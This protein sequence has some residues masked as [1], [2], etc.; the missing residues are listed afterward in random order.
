MNKWYNKDRTIM[1]DLDK[2]SYY[3]YLD[4]TDYDYPN[5]LYF[6]LDGVNVEFIGEEALELFNALK[7]SNKEVI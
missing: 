2:V 4:M 5:K 3:R 6:I 1:V 7:K